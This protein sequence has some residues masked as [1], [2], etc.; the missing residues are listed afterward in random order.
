MAAYYAVK[1]ANDRKAKKAA[2]DKIFARFDHNH[3]GERDI[4]SAFLQ[5]PPFRKGFCE[6]LLWGAA[7]GRPRS[8][9]GGS[10]EVD[11]F[12][13]RR[14]SSHKGWI[15]NLLQKFR[16]LSKPG[17]VSHKSC[18]CK[19]EICF[20]S[21]ITMEWCRIWRWPARPSWRSRPLTRTAMA[22]SPRESS[23]RSQSLSPRSRSFLKTHKIKAI[24]SSF[25]KTL[26]VDQHLELIYFQ[27]ATVLA[28]FDQDGDGKL[29]YAEFKKLLK[30]WNYF[31]K[32][33]LTNFLIL[34]L[35]LVWY[36]NKYFQW[37]ISYNSSVYL[38]NYSAHRH[39][40][41]MTTLL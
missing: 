37:Q 32:E 38:L 10:S 9:R 40:Q 12:R 7:P 28:R 26:Y 36:V 2:F 8:R 33:I 20:N 31:G 3:N 30:K 4:S 24:K 22:S 21:G 35:L 34:H 11:S 29:S 19:G 17:Q 5:L 23:M 13:R 39:L 1:S 15:Q 14:R 41:L 27:I 16:A 25:S 6:R 18:K